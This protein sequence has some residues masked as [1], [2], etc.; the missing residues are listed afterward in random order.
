MSPLMNILV[1]LYG[2]SFYED[3]EEHLELLKE[4]NN[5][6]R[7][8]RIDIEQQA[9]FDFL[10]LG[11]TLYIKYQ[12][13]SDDDIY[14]SY[15]DWFGKVFVED[16]N[17]ALIE[18]EEQTIPSNRELCIC[19]LAREAKYKKIPLETIYKF[20]REYLIDAEEYTTFW[21]EYYN[22]KYYE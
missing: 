9:K 16:Y 10:D 2:E 3:F 18:V 5:Y 12:D 20:C 21:L 4:I 15:S 7:R 8:K 17:K 14:W 22:T 19:R 1:N 13:D 11:N 6:R